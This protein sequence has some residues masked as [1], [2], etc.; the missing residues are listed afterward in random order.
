MLLTV[1]YRR[2][3][4]IKVGPLSATLSVID[5]LRNTVC[6]SSRSCRGHA[7]GRRTTLLMPKRV[8]KRAT[9]GVSRVT[10]AVLP[11][12]RNEA[13]G[14]SLPLSTIPRMICL[15]AAD[16]RWKP[17]AVQASALRRSRDTV[18]VSKNATDTSPGSRLSRGSKKWSI[19]TA[20][21]FNFPTCSSRFELPPCASAQPRAI[22]PS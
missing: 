10:S 7:P 6:T 5:S 14:R 11:G 8:R 1:R 3:R 19:T 16:S 21:L 18:V 17:P 9:T 12:H 4:M 15:N 13:N 22:L 20:T 2:M